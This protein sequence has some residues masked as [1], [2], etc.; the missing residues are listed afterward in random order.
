[1]TEDK[2]VHFGHFVRQRHFD[3][4]MSV[5]EFA[6]KVGRSGRWLIGMERTAASA[7]DIPDV[8][9]GKIAKALGMAGSEQLRREAASTPVPIARFKA[10][11]PHAKKPQG[12][13]SRVQE[14]KDSGHLATI[15][16]DGSSTRREV[17][18]RRGRRKRQP[19]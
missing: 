11:G 17:P 8:S 1:M 4:G 2:H 10:S 7:D 6:E 13:H 14:S 3:L 18:E 16:H 12:H 19:R 5:K 9:V 15:I